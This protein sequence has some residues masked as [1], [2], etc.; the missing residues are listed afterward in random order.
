MEEILN[1]K[2]NNNT[3][4]IIILLLIISNMFI[5]SNIEIKF[6]R[7]VKDT[8]KDIK[9]IINNYKLFNQTNERLFSLILYFSNHNLNINSEKFI[10]FMNNITKQTFKDIQILFIHN[11]SNH[12]I[13]NNITNKFMKELNI[14]IYSAKSEIWR[15]K[16][17]Y[18]AQKLKGKF[19][20]S[21]N[22]II[23]FEIDEFYKIYNKI[24]GGIQNIFEF[25]Y[26]NNQTLYLLRIKKINEIIDSE[27]KFNDYNQL[28]TIDISF[29]H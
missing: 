24:K 21:I 9:P 28:I 13:I 26:D 3:Y 17:L 11:L 23:K 27:I 29:I 4:K 7:K 5:L 1:Y 8:K 18:L 15:D 12:N 2:C 16:F 19:L 22:N 25:T 10:N 14:E 20:L 6:E